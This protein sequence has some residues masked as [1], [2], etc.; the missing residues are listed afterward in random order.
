MW[1]YP[2]GVTPDPDAAVNGIPTPEEPSTNI[3]PAA[4]ARSKAA[5]EREAAAEKKA[6]DAAAAPT[7]V[8]F[9]KMRSGHRH[10]HREEP[11]IEGHSDPNFE[12]H[13]ILPNTLYNDQRNKIPSIHNGP[14]TSETVWRSSMEGGE[15]NPDKFRMIIGKGTMWNYPTQQTPDDNAPANGIPAPELPTL[16]LDDEV[17]AAEKINRAKE[18]AQMLKEEADAKAAFVKAAKEAEEEK[19]LGKQIAKS[20]S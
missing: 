16:N 5:A 2:K 19:S 17:V 11:D 12:P 14:H 7:G 20:M 4:I 10:G 8:T 15:P 18:E 3:D 13:A 6:D 9:V 1:N